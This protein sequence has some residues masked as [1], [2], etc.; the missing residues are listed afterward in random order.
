MKKLIALL[1]ALVMVFGMVACGAK[2]EEPAAPEAAPEAAP[3]EKEEAPEAAPAEEEHEPVTL[4]CWNFPDTASHAFMDTFSAEVNAKYPW[5]TLEWETLPF[6]SGPEKITVAYATDTTPDLLFDGY[7]R[8]APAVHADLCVDLTDVV[9]KN[10]DQ[11][12][13]LP[14]DGVVDGKYYYIPTNGAMGYSVVVNMDLAEKLGVADMLPEDNLT[15]SYDDFLALCRAT[16]AADSSVYPISLFAGSQSSD[17]WYYSFFLG[18]GVEICNENLTATAFN[19]DKNREESLEVLNFF[20]TLIDEELV[21]PGAATAID[22]DIGQY[23]YSGLTLM[24]PCAFTNSTNYYN[25][26]QDGTISERDFELFALPTADG[27][28]PPLSAMWGTGGVVGFKNNGHEEAIKLV[29]D[30]YLSNESNAYAEGLEKIGHVPVLAESKGAV[31]LAEDWLTDMFNLGS[32]YSAEYAVADF[33][34]LEPWWGEFRGGLYP[35]LQDFYTGKIDAQTVLDN[36]QA[37]GDNV[38]STALAAE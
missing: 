5:I 31:N 32:V 3:A 30:L 4:T 6:D 38:I 1:L 33:G 12:L 7:S 29:L 37:Y 34:I 9:T 24:M 8:L 17:A 23:W 15:W 25:M 26:I 19:D 22:G 10:A 36:W 18:N 28:Q 27:V 11:F 13:A 20:K 16:R 35:Q 21:T 2:T 14:K